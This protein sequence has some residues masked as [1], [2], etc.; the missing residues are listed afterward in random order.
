MRCHL[1]AE[2]DDNEEDDFL[3]I[4]EERL[5]E[6]DYDQS[7]DTDNEYLLNGD[8]YQNDDTDNDDGYSDDFKFLRNHRYD[9]KKPGPGYYYHEVDDTD[10][11]AGIDFLQTKSVGKRR[12]NAFLSHSFRL[13]YNETVK[14]FHRA[15][16]LD[17]DMIAC[18]TFSQIELLSASLPH[19]FL[20]PFS[21]PSSITDFL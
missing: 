8:Y 10:D 5:A 12:L 17:I 14:A 18:I 11:D 21:K 16:N 1:H 2:N 3:K 6:P 9:T 19:F 15:H 7:L 20:F 13:G 4:L